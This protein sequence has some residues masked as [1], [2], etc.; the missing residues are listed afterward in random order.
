MEQKLGNIAVL[1]ESYSKGVVSASGSAALPV[2][3]FGL[4]LGVQVNATLDAKILIGYL[5]AKI[6]GPIPAE[7]AAFLESALAIS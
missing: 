1:D 5:A 7:V 6:G 2:N 4:S 3:A